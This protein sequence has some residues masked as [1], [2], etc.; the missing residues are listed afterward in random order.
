MPPH[1]RAWVP[2][3]FC[4]HQHATIEEAGACARR[5]FAGLPWR[6]VRVE[7][8]SIGAE[9]GSGPPAASDMGTVARELRRR[10]RDS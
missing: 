5:L 7:D 2:D 3:G 4:A 8:M 6:V 10:V 9:T 1:F